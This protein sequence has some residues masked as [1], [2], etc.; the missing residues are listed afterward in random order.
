M[1]TLLNLGVRIPNDV[2]V[3]GLDDIYLNNYFSPSLTTVR[4]PLKEIARIAVDNLL[5]PDTVNQSKEIALPGELI[6]RE[7]STRI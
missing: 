4:Q 3:T 1:S 7:S 2:L 5:N 6:V